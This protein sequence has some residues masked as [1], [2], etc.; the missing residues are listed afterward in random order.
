MARP[1]E[2]R[3]SAEQSPREI[4]AALD[5]VLRSFSAASF[6]LASRLSDKAAD[7]EIL[8]SQRVHAAVDD[9]IATEP[10]EP[11][12]LKCFSRPV[13]AFNVSAGAP[14]RTLA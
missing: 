5:S 13:P 14:T 1:V 2:P 11:L 3:A 6:E 4:V 7:G 10:V 9:H 12:E 8:L